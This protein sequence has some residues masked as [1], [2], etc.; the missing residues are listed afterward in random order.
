MEGARRIDMVALRCGLSVTVEHST[1]VPRPSYRTAPSRIGGR[2]AW[3]NQGF[4]V[5]AAEGSARF[6][7]CA[8]SF[9]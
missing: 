7:A 2:D 9:A 5:V 6:I 3:S 4:V 8:Y 1:P